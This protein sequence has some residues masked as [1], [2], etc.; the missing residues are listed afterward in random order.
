MPSEQPR[1]GARFAALLTSL[2]ETR[3]APDGHVFTPAEVSAGTGLPTAYLSLLRK[4]RVARPPDEKVRALAAFFGVDPLYF[5][6]LTPSPV[7]PRASDIDRRLQEALR[8]PLVRDVALRAAEFGPAEKL[9]LLEVIDNLRRFRHAGSSSAS[10]PD[11]SSA[12]PQPTDDIPMETSRDSDGEGIDAGDTE[13][14]R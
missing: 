6:T 2:W 3:R 13:R 8:D 10:T 4:G 1:P 9:I 11:A 7:A 5:S 12:R 14:D